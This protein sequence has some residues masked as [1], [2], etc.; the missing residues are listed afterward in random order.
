M[1][2][3]GKRRQVDRKNV[4]HKVPRFCTKIVDVYLYGKYWLAQGGKSFCA[5]STLPFQGDNDVKNWA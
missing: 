4:H 3:R 5:L 2:R 1:W